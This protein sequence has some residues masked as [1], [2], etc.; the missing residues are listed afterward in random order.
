M[1]TPA[2]LADESRELY[3]NQLIELENTIDDHLYNYFNGHGAKIPG[4][5]MEQLNPIVQ[6]LLIEKYDSGGWTLDFEPTT[7]IGNVILY[8]REKK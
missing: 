6:K 5:E 4:I 1:I 2:E 7:T 3:K 8:I